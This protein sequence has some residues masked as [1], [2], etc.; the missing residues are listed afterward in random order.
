[1][2]TQERSA[3]HR[4]WVKAHIDEVREY[5]RIWM[6]AKRKRFT[7]EEIEHRRKLINQWRSRTKGS[8]AAHS[9]VQVAKRTGKLV[10]QPC[11]SCGE[12]KSQAHHND[13]NK[14]LAVIWLCAACH[15]NHHKKTNSKNV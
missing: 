10:P 3:Y 12:E 5:Q 4:R 8:A 6:R 13:Y 9:A 11:E 2:T 15:R 1:M 14:P 7:E